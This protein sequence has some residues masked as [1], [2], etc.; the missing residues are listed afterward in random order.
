MQDDYQDMLDMLK[1]TSR[2]SND[3]DSLRQKVFDAVQNI[4]MSEDWRQQARGF[5]IAQ[6]SGVGT[7]RNALGQQ[8]RTP[9]QILQNVQAT[10]QGALQRASSRRKPATT[11]FYTILSTMNPADKN[12]LIDTLMALKTFSF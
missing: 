10:A 2:H 9:Q 7:I 4:A 11:R 6:P 5:K 1:K 3:L 12:N 8:N